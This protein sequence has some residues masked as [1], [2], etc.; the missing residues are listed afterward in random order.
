RTS[1]P[2]GV[3]AAAPPPSGSSPSITT[4]AV[5][6]TIETDSLAP[7]PAPPTFTGAMARPRSTAY[8]TYAIATAA[9]VLGGGLTLMLAKRRTPDAAPPQVIVTTVQVPSTAAPA[10]DGA[11][12][13]GQGRLVRIESEPAGASVSDRGTEVCMSTPCELFWK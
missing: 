9:A 5:A 10:S 2:K 12:A 7:P 6:A 4:Q 1:E 3:L 8:R 13:S 11:N